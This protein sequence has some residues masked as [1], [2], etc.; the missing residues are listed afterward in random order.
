MS[1]DVALLIGRILITIALYGFIGVVFIYLIKDLRAIEQLED[2]T[3]YTPAYLRV[4]QS[5]LTDVMPDQRFTVHGRTRIGR[6]ATCDIVLA[7]DFVSLEHARI[8]HK[9]GQWWLIEGNSRNGTLVNGV[10]VEDDVILAP[11]DRLRIGRVTLM[12]EVT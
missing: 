3:S 9:N 8:Q 7:D 1:L 4:T 6:A 12:F 10:R 11:G 5:D 2:K